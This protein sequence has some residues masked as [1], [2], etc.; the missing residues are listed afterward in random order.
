MKLI[1]TCLSFVVACLVALIPQIFYLSPLSDPQYLQIPPAYKFHP[2]NNKLQ[3][4]IKLGEGHLKGP[5][6]TC[7]DKE[8]IL[9][10]VSRDGWIKRMHENETWESWKKIESDALLGITT[11]ILGGLIVCDAERGLLKVTE[12][13]VTVL[14]S[15]MNGSRIRF[16]DDVI[17]ASDGRMYFSVASTKFGLHDWYLDLLEAIP[18]GQ[19]LIYDPSLNHTS[20]LLQEL[21]FPNGVALSPQEDYLV[22]CETWKFRCQKYW[23]KGEKKGKTEILIDNL[24]GGPDNINLAPDGTFWIALL[25]LIPEGLEFVHYSKPLKHI[26]A[27]F[28]KLVKLLN[29][30]YRK[31][32]VIN[33]GSD[34]K[35]IRKFDDPD[36]KVMTFITSALE[37][38]DH[39]FLGSLNTNFVGKL[40]LKSE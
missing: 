16:A 28:P 17:E 20:I 12:D 21:A 31:A 19:L 18:H 40:S 22:F 3:Q 37:Y 7:V 2:K 32:S 25:Q 38:K 35:I 13:G 23:L 24:P 15:E 6:D 30:V 1:T 5:E 29:G 10:A 14:A 8:G 34:G 27:S 36:G 9:Y 4:V 33:V 39:L 11:S 26:V